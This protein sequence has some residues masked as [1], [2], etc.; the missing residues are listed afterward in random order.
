[1]VEYDGP[2]TGADLHALIER[3]AVLRADYVNPSAVA[4]D[5]LATA[6]SVI[7]GR[8]SAGRRE[9]KFRDVVQIANP[10]LPRLKLSNDGPVVRFLVATIPQITGEQL[11]PN[12]VRQ[13]LRRPREGDNPG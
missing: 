9:E 3:N 11:T 10:N 8:C 13:W 12:A 5:A 1:M 2:I 4:L 7:R 6:V